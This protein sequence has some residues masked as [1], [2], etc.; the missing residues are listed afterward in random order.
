MKLDPRVSLA[1][2]LLWALA[3]AGAGTLPGLVLLPMDLLSDLGA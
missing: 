1:A 2:F 3:V